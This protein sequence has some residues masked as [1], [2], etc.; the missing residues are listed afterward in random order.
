MPSGKSRYFHF[1]CSNKISRHFSRMILGYSI[2]CHAR[3]HC[4]SK[5]HSKS[6]W[7]QY[8]LYKS[9]MWLL[10]KHKQ[11]VNRVKIFFQCSN[12]DV[13]VLHKRKMRLVVLVCLIVVRKQMIQRKLQRK[14]QRNHVKIKTTQYSRKEASRDG[15]SPFLKTV[16]EQNLTTEPEVPRNGESLI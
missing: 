12:F 2:I 7:I 16:V 8:F 6:K 3:F 10:N 5:S 15:N 4:M 13:E 11:F 1:L 9:C 14:L